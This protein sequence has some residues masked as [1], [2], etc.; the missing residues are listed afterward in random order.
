M[1]WGDLSWGLSL[2]FLF[3]ASDLLF[4][5]AKETSHAWYVKGYSYQK[6][7]AQYLE[8]TILRKVASYSN[9]EFC[10]TKP[11][12]MILEEAPLLCHRHCQYLVAVVGVMLYLYIK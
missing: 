6:T 2:T 5:D 3:P 8:D 9:E 12:K 4:P 1:L 10:I 7:S 11:F